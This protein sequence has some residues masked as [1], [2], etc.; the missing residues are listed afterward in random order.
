MAAERGSS[1]LAVIGLMAVAGVATLA[2]AGSTMNSIGVSSATRAGVQAQAAA[3]AGIDAALANLS[4]PTCTELW[5]TTT[6]V[7]TVDVFYSMDPTPVAD[8]PDENWLPGCPATNAERVKIKSKGTADQAGQA[9]N[10]SG[11]SRTVEA[12]YHYEAASAETPA[13]GAGTALYSYASGSFGGSSQLH[14]VDHPVVTDVPITQSDP[15]PVIQIKTGNA[16][17]AGSSIFEADTVVQQGS[18]S[19]DGSCKIMG[20]VWASGGTETGG[21]S[22]LYGNVATSDLTTGGSSQIYGSAWASQD[23]DTSGSSIIHGNL[24]TTRLTKSG[25]SQ[26]IGDVSGVAAPPVAPTVPDWVDVGY[27]TSDWPGFAVTTTSTG[28]DLTAIQAAVTAFSTREPPT[29]GII[30]ARGCSGGVT[31]QGNTSL[32]LPQDIAIFAAEFHISGSGHF[33]SDSATEPRNLWLITPD[34]VDDNLPTPCPTGDNRDSSIL[35]SFIVSAP[36]RVMLYTPCEIRLGGS[37]QWRG[38]FYGG[39]VSTVGSSQLHYTPI[40]IPGA[41]IPVGGTP[42]SEA[43]EAKLG[44][45]ISIRD[46]NVREDG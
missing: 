25:T 14:W 2:I 20:N 44:D 31:I 9:G 12:I 23:T 22:I 11:D 19:S 46:L 13:T 6:P 3:E 7:S 5:G 8:E 34:E 16:S 15:R 35:G 40:G 32:S 4:Q 36:V 10:E 28:C 38:Q 43:T 26:V 42:G 30:D 45:R 17:C 1:M 27:D 24:A 21:S 39:S 29:K 33:V 18:F 41:E 37:A